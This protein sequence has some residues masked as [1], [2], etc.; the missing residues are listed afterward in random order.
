MT[1]LI[2]RYLFNRFHK[3]FHHGEL[4]EKDPIK[5]Y[6]QRNG[7]ET[8][9]NFREEEVTVF[10]T[11]KVNEINGKILTHDH[12]APGE[13][14]TMKSLLSR[15]S[16]DYFVNFNLYACTVVLLDRL[17]SCTNV[18]TTNARTKKQVIFLVL[19]GATCMYVH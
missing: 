5:N 10:D 6:V 4:H 19:R 2:W 1:L 9:V 3:D 17:K 15:D 13:K 18:C 7:V 12:T 11:R 8:N 16:T 14:T